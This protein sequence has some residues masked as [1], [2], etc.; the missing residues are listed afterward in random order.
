[1]NDIPDGPAPRP[2]LEGRPMTI[3][4]LGGP[5]KQTHGTPERPFPDMDRTDVANPERIVAEEDKRAELDAE[6]VEAIRREDAR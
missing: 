5:E 1:M 4:N 3:E 6:A 2:D